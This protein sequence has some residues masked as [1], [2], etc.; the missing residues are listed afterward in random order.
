[1]VARFPSFGGVKAFYAVVE[2]GRVKDAAELLGIS[3]SA[4]SHQI[5]KLEQELNIRLLEADAGKLRP[6]T[7]GLRYFQGI[8][9]GLKAILNATE[10]LRSGPGRQRVTLTLTPSCAANWLLPRLRDIYLKHPEI[11]L[12]LVTTTRVC[13]LS[14]EHIDIAIRRGLGE[15]EYLESKRLLE[16]TVVPVLA[17]DLAASLDGRSIT[18]ILSAT[19]ILVNNVLPDEWDEWCQSRGLAAPAPK[20]RFLLETYELTIQAARDRL[21]IALGRRP[22]ID[23][24]LANG[25]LVSPSVNGHRDSLGYYVVWCRNTELTG[26]AKKVLAWLLSQASAK[27]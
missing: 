3:A 21:G 22:L 7:D 1:V 6:T 15:W 12:N 25:E 10:E 18:E 5:K 4:V 17:R 20:N 24:L 27:T 16:E 23:G 13:D 11:E 26:P 9:P 19:K 14:R 2:T 8:Q